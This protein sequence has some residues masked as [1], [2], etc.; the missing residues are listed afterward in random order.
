MKEYYENLS[1]L[2]KNEKRANYNIET[3]DRKSEIVVIAPHGGGIEPGTSEI[4]REISGKNLSLLL[5]EGLLKKYNK[6]RLHVTSTHIDYEP[7]INILKNAK[8]S[9]SIHGTNDPNLNFRNVE[10][11]GL[12]KTLICN[13]SKKLEKYGYD[14]VKSPLCR[15]AMSIDNIVNRS[16]EMGCQLELS[17]ELRESF[18]NGSLRNIQAREKLFK[19]KKCSKF[20]YE[21]ANAIKD[22]LN[23]YI[24]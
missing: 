9:I 17:K 16:V 19:E 23:S 24:G 15:N 12:N 4:A 1:R 6:K 20:F 7:W 2:L 11:S 10:L 13:I 22:S 14:V 8:I 18:F 3:I 5:F 21:F